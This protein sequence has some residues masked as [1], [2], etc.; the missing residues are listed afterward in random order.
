VLL[1]GEHAVV[2]GRPALAAPLPLGVQ[3]E[4]TPAG[5]W[6][7][8]CE[9]WG[10]FTCR[11]GEA[12]T[13]ARG[14]AAL[15]E[16][17][18]VGLA[19]HHMRVQGDLPAG[20]GL[21]S[22]AALAVAL[23]RTLASLQG[24]PLDD[25]ALFDAAMG[26]EQV[27][28]GQP[29]GLDVQAAMRTQGAFLFRR[30]PDGVHLQPVRPGCAVPLCIVQAEP[31]ADTG[32]MVA[33]VSARVAREP[34]LMAEVLDGMG[35]AALAGADALLRGDLEA[36]GACMDIAH[37]LLMAAGV[38][39]AGLDAACHRL[40]A[41]GAL[42]AKLTGAGGGG[43]LVAVCPPDR[44]DAVVASARTWAMAAWG[45][46]LPADPDEAAPEAP[47]SPYPAR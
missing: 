4:A 23:C 1:F 13:L 22:S 43:C 44:L 45:V 19:P 29:S 20:A 32:R 42:G 36:A 38:S 35:E 5:A 24:T 37:G 39:T 27:F 30:R 33:G 26:M 47:P 41:A 25:R 14:F 18:G 10:G 7:L 12:G 31:G 40:R 8:T 16:R 3:V 15:V 17:L 28:H 21:G 11:A 34:R 46:V 9:L 2:R 6:Q